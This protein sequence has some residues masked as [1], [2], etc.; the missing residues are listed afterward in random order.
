MS[1]R[2]PRI[3]LLVRGH[4]RGAF[5]SALFSDYARGMGGRLGAD[6]RAFVHTWS[7]SEARQSHRPL[8]RAGVRPVSEGD[9]RAYFGDLLEWAAVDDD[10]E[11]RLPGSAEGRIGGIPA[12]PWKNMWYGKH[13]AAAAIEESGLDFDLVVCVRVDNFLNMES[14][15]HAHINVRTMDDACRRAL[16]CGD[17]ER[18]HFV[19]DTTCPGIDNFYTGRPHA[20]FRLIDRFHYEMDDVRRAYPDVHHQEF[21]VYHEAGRMARLGVGL[22]P[23]HRA[24]PH[25]DRDQDPD[26]RNVRDRVV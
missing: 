15:R 21:M 6:V 7:E 18:V 9:V 14:R 26:H 20:V 8:R 22:S 19:K 5:A 12:R 4:E 3:A 11:I 13:R 2:R 17:P 1:R 16:A 25:G 24:D 10:R 23:G